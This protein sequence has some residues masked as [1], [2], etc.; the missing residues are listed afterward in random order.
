MERNAI[1]PAVENQVNNQVNNNKN[2]NNT[3][4]LANMFGEKEVAAPKV[5]DQQTVKDLFQAFMSIPQEVT[6]RLKNDK[7]YLK[8]V[9]DMNF[10]ERF[11]RSYETY[12]DAKLVE[13]MVGAMRG[14]RINSLD[15][16]KV[17]EHPLE[18]SEVDPRI[19]LFRLFLN[20]P[21]R[22]HFDADLV[23]K[24]GDRYM[25]ATFNV[26]YKKHFKFCLKRTEELEAIINEFI[27]EALQTA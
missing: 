13:N 5:V 26:S 11:L 20:S 7:G 16:Y 18:A 25:C 15:L 2:M 4:N 22:C 23:G 14:D 3:M 27:N 19:E 12:A 24:N 8:M 9:V 21:M 17:E 1:N 10:R 6:V